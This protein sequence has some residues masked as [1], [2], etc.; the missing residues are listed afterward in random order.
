MIVLVA[1]S[2]FCCEVEET[3]S[4]ILFIDGLSTVD[5]A[6]IYLGR[7]LPAASSSQPESSQTSN[8]PEVCSARFRPLCLALLQMGFTRPPGHP[9]AGEL[10]PHHFTLTRHELSPGGLFLWH[11]P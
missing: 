3:I 7:R 6:I 2:Y 8:L 5:E 1:P 9:A 11:F 4:R 10:L